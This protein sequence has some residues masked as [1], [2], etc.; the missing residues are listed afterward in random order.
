MAD[1]TIRPAE[2]H[3]RAWMKAYITQQWGEPRVVA[4]GAVYRPHEL[5]GLLAEEGDRRVG[6]LTYRIEGDA[7]EIV[8]IDATVQGSGVGT[9]LLDAVR[10]VAQA[11]GCRRLW[12]VTTNDNLDA[13]RFYQRRGFR[14]S[15]LRPGALIESRRI[16][17][18]IPLTGEYGIPLRD[19]LELE[20]HLPDAF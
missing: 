17:P 8:T 12:V 20:M 5:P 15:A 14:L 10:G 1:W 3:D 4:H 16:K 11:H 6:L 19:E 13:L 18:S 7:C 9:A 2:P